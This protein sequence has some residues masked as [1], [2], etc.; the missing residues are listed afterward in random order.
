MPGVGSKLVG[1]RWN[2][3]GRAVVYTSEHPATALLE[4]LVHAERPQLV[5]DSFV[6][7]SADVPEN[8]VRTLEITSLAAGWNALGDSRVAQRIGDAWYDEQVSVALRVPSV[9]LKGQLNVLLN[10]EHSDWAGVALGEPE[11][12]VFDPRLTR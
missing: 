11:P 9:I 1:G 6:M 8:L 4:V 3:S 12:F 10:P 2:S 7:L 5:R